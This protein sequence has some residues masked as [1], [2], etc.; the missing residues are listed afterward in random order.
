MEI[1]I[2]LWLQNFREAAGR[3]ITP[4]ML[5]VSDFADLWILFVPL[6]VYWVFNKKGGLMLFIGCEAAY[7]LMRTSKLIFCGLRPFM[8]DARI[9]PAFSV[10]GWSFPSGHAVT[11][12]AVYGGLAWLSRKRSPLFSLMCVILMVLT[13]FSRNYLGIHFLRDTVG[14]LALGLVALW[15]V[16]I[17]LA[18]TKRENKAV[19][20]WIVFC[21]ISL[22]YVVFKSYPVDSPVDP[23]R[24]IRTEFYAVGLIAGIILGRIIERKYIHFYVTGLNVKGA[25]V[26]LIGC[27]GFYVLL[28]TDIMRDSLRMFLPEW[29]VRFMMGV[30]LTFYVVALWPM[31]IKLMGGRK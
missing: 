9:V 6:I 18:D 5:G 17:S 3:V 31:V 7:L 10:T 26:T 2:L 14:G 25:V 19:I 23:S 1:E 16:N 20:F 4:L 12:G 30:I 11:A 29:P 24:E 28:F 22:V 27:A 21:V 15:A 13:V 8:V